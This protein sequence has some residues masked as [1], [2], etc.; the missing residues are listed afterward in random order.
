MS[1][2]LGL[3]CRVACPTFHA[4]RHR[5]WNS[6]FSSRDRFARNCTALWS[7]VLTGVD[8]GIQRNGACVVLWVL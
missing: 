1:G 2:T 5:D 6:G 8:E 7:E 3:P 4:L